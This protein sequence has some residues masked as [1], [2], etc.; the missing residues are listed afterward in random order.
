[1]K[2]TIGGL[3]L[4][5][6]LVGLAGCG[7][8][9]Q[10]GPSPTPS[11]TGEIGIPPGETGGTP[12]H[13]PGRKPMQITLSRTGGIAGV[14]QRVVV[15]PEGAWTYTG[16]GKRK[17]GELT[18]QQVSKLQSL[19]MDERLPAEAKRQDSGECADGFEYSLKAGDVSLTAVDCGGFDN[20][21]VFSELVD[22]LVDATP[23]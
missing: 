1:M 20:R 6:V 11:G 21:P 14:D 3:L 23:M 2:R 16:D 10:A 8:G 13:P 18:D 4:T 19:A 22:L 12:T 5:A 15:E 17:T 9:G 7:G